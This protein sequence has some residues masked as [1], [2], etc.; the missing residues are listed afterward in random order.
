MQHLPPSAAHVCILKADNC[1][2]EKQKLE[3]EEE[4]TTKINSSHSNAAYR[5]GR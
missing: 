2:E 1:A 5:E 4:N 3:E